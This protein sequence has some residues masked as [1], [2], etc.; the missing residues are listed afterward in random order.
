M[1][2]SRQEYWSGLPFLSPGDLPDPEIE[3][4]SPALQ[5]DALPDEH[6]GNPPKSNESESESEVVSDSLRPH[7]LQP[8]RLLPPW[9]SPGKS[10][11]VGCHFF[12]QGIFLTQRWNPGFLHCRQTLYH[13]NHS[14]RFVLVSHCGFNLHFP[15]ASPR[16]RQPGM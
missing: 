9:D 4:W 2:F 1:K 3:P 12:L 11:G 10:T 14:E 16:A 5:A 7:G 15:N 6:P 8:T 13:L